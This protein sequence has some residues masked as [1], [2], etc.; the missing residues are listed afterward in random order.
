MNT[1]IHVSAF[2]ILLLV[3]ND[4]DSTISIHP[5]NFYY[6]IGSNVT[7][8]CFINYQKSSYIDVN[9]TLYMEWSYKGYTENA[10]IPLGGDAKHS[11]DYT[12]DWL[13]L[14]DAGHYICLHFITAAVS[15]PN[16]KFSSIKSNTASIRAISKS[17]INCDGLLNLNL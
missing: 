4:F 14:S 3:P 1:L 8:K 12:I 16:I 15:D 10:T 7:L 6:E 5:G 13:K 2:I 11:L 9:T 17:M